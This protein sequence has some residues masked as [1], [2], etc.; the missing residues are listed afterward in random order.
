[1]IQIDILGKPAKLWFSHAVC[2]KVV[3]APNGA[4]FVFRNVRQTVCM[5]VDPADHALAHGEAICAEGDNFCK[6]TG[7]KIALSRA[8]RNYDKPT[9][10][11]IWDAYF[12]ARGKF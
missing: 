10:K 5:V 9:R 7:R 3:A 12:K 11:K 4:R 1:M 8:I 6:N 2:P